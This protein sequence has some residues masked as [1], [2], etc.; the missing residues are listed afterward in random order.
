MEFKHLV[1]IKEADLYIKDELFLAGIPAIK[2]EK[3]EREIP[4][5]I[6]GKL[7]DWNFGRAWYYWVASAQNGKGLSLE[8]ATQLHERQY[9]IIG[10][11]QPKI[12]GKVIRVTGHC[13]CPHPRDWALPTGEILRKE[14]Q[15]LGKKDATYGELAILLNSGQIKAP[16]F[17]NLYHIDNQI[18]LNEFVKVIK[19]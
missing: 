5:S 6:T 3:S 4:Y 1:G 14:T 12:Y 8:V 16:R 9:P 13:G 15:R 7:G 18:G 11:D 17:V 10:E 19:G 2:G